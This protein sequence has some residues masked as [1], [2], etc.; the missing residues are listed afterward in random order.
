MSTAQTD[1]LT[2]ALS[3][4]YRVE[5][6]LGAGGM[7]TVYLAH[8]LKHDRDVAIKVLHPELGAAL[9]G[10]RFLTEIRTTARL[11][12]PHILPLLDSGDADGLLYYVMPLVTGETLRARLERER[13]LPI[14]DA[15]LIAREVA[16]ALHYAH[17]LGVIHR[18]IKPENIL[19]QNGH[20][21]VAD[22]G[23]ALAV[24]SA[25]GA[26]MTQT[27]LSLGTPQYMSPE[28]AMGERTID[29]RSDIYALGAMTYEMLAG[30]APFTGSSVPAIVAKVLSSEPEPL[31][32]VRKTVPEHIETAV[33]TA[34]AKLPADRYASAAEF[35][36]AL[37]AEGAVRSTR[38][39][40]AER[41]RGTQQVRGLR[42]ALGAV[43]AL[44]VIA[45]IAASWAW[46]RPRAQA[47][48]TVAQFEL[49]APP[50]LAHALRQD[51]QSL[52]ISPD[53]KLMTIGV[54]TASGFSLAVRSLDQLVVRVLPG[55]SEAA[56]PAFSPDG[57]WI[58]FDAGDGFLKKIA[59]DGTSLTTIGPV[60]S[61]GSTGVTWISDQE[62]VYT[63]NSLIADPFASRVS[64]NGGPAVRA[65]RPDSANN[66]RF[67]TGPVSVGDG[68]H[69]VVSSTT[70]NSGFNRVALL[71]LKDSTTTVFPALSSAR[72]LG[73]I[74]GAVVYVQPDG[75]LMAAPI[76]LSARTVGVAV[77]LADSISIRRSGA[78]AALSASG[79]LL[80]LR[81]GA[82]RELVRVTPAGVATKL[83]GAERSYLHPR[84][85]PDGRRVAFEVSEQRG[86]DIW[87][88]DLALQTTERVTRDGSSDR[89]EWSPDG[90][91]LL[92]S[93]GRT[94]PYTL[95][96]QPADGSG[97]GVKLM[98]G[99]GLGAREGVYTPDGRGVVYRVDTEGNARDILQLSLVGDRT[100]VPLLVGPSDDKQPR[101]SP[102]GRWLAYVSNESGREEVYVRA[103]A[104]SGGRVA[105]SSGGGGEPLWSR[106]G[107]RLFYREGSKLMAA[108]LAI[109]TQPAVTARAVLFEGP[110]E[111]D[112]L[113]PNYDVFPDGTG[114][115]MVRTNEESRRLVVELN[116]VSKLR[117][118]LGRAK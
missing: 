72:V 18:D 56:F 75:A 20:A 85:S 50:G 103:L 113:H 16:D 76:N 89:P 39:A 49:P 109:T 8:D 70:N 24:Q 62:L 4:R 66:D 71:D 58:A 45:T 87:V 104:P 117:Q 48:A 52:A 91:R 88:A 25:G 26:R 111:T 47:S 32:V 79:T 115:V 67:H 34:L 77:Q 30:D 69:V 90:Q 44:A 22:F 107:R 105:V 19:L 94:T 5:R 2:A 1:R 13:Q 36:A 43:A 54:M 74:D 80:T 61:G 116:W 41:A 17:G 100:P 38:L 31:S 15:M 14:A 60:P 65:A 114:F 95:Y 92:Y 118:R 51:L 12:H 98:N 21:L 108:D 6:E 83:L 37:Q 11:Q 23:I 63:G 64:A 102:D 29:A 96:E 86:T 73:V 9:G 10:E 7:A 28:Q 40:S 106:D 81:G 110:F 33:L 99:T 46:K 97:P 78:G 55:T 112:G 27:G 42:I 53:G 93:S 101:V 3:D 68:R 57:K 59:V 84:L 35:A 82:T